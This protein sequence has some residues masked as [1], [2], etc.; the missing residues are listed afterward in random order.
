MRGGVDGVPAATFYTFPPKKWL[1]PKSTNIYYS[2][3]LHK[4][5]GLPFDLLYKVVVAISNRD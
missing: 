1:G 4:S 2:F 5:W 3:V